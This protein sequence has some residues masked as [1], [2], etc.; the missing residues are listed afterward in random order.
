VK[1]YWADEDRRLM[2][3]FLCLTRGYH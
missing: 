1:P 2:P 3:D